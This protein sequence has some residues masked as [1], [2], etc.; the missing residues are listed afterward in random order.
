VFSVHPGLL[1]IGM[2]EDIATRPPATAYEAHVRDWAMREL[3]AGR[4]AHPEQVV[5]LVLRLAVGDADS[6]SG[7]HLSVH[8]DLDAVL[9]RLSEVHAGDLYV[10]RPDRLRACARGARPRHRPA[11]PAYLLGRHADVW[12]TA[13][14]RR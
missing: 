10:L 4:G 1:P 8:D 2:S 9:A 13:L 14:A 7:R 5:A 12:R 11:G 3:D 6:L